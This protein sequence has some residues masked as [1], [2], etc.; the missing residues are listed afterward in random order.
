MIQVKNP[1]NL[2]ILKEYRI[3][4]DGLNEDISSNSKRI[5][6][7]SATH[8]GMMRALGVL[9]KLVGIPEWEYVCESFDKSRIKAVGDIFRANAESYAAVQPDLIFYSGYDMNTPIFNKFKQIGLKTFLM[10]EW[11]ENHPLGRAE[12]IKIYGILFH[13]EQEANAIFED[14]RIKYENLANKLQ[15][16][17][18]YP[19]ALSGTYWGDI[20]NA[21]TGR[22]YNAQLLADANVNYVYKEST[23]TGSLELSLEE[24]INDNK[25]VENWINM[26]ATSRK[27]LLAQ[28]SKFALLR[29]V[30]LGNLYSYMGNMNCFFENSAIEPHIVLEDIAK[31]FHPEVFEDTEMKYYSKLILE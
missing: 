6:A 26:A 29:S 20:F 28:N 11:K 15:Q 27:E 18:I 24:V 23:G 2:E 4:K 21:P 13:K 31:I 30:K 3:T 5:I 16:L 17:S 14:I 22:S 1:D 25:D 8:I 7:G 19:Q 12:W 10:Y 9:D